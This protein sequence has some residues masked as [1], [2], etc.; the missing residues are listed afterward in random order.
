MADVVLTHSIL[1]FN[2]IVLKHKLSSA[3][4][5]LW[6]PDFSGATD[7]ESREIVGLGD[8]IRENAAAEATEDIH[9]TLSYWYFDENGNDL[10]MVEGCSMG[11]ALAYPTELLFYNVAQC[12]LELQFLMDKF[13]IVY[14][15]SSLDPV[16]MFVANWIN[17]NQNENI[18]VLGINEQGTQ[19]PESIFHPMTQF[20]DLKKSLSGSWLD[21]L[22]GFLTKLLQP[23]QRKNV[24]IL[25]N[26]KFEDY[27]NRRKSDKSKQF[28]IIAPIR[29]NLKIGYGNGVFWQRTNAKRFYPQVEIALRDA[30]ERGWRIKSKVIP[31]DLL[32]SALRQFVFDHWHS[33]FS[34][35]LH[36][37][38]LFRFFK[39]KLAV[40][41]S[42]STEISHLGAFAAKIVGLPVIVMAHGISP[43][44]NYSIMNRSDKLFDKYCSIGG[45]D[46]QKYSDCGLV[47]KDIEEIKFPW[48]SNNKHTSTYARN[49]Q[50]SERR[51]MLLPLDTGFSLLMSASSIMNHIKQ[52]IE[53]CEFCN[54][55][56]FGIKFRTQ[57]EANAFG[58]TVGENYIFGR[59]IVVYAGY[60]SLSNYFGDIDSIIGPF[61]SGTAECG[62]AN[63]DYFCFQDCSIYS[64]NPNVFYDSV[65]T[66]CPIA[67]NTDELRANILNNR[68]F[69]EGHDATSLVSVSDDFKNACKEL[70][71][72]FEKYIV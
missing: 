43:W 71:K 21:N 22:I 46:N 13:E 2:E 47:K 11:T 30:N 39:V 37:I 62:L 28:S 7:C 55:Q 70:D 8:N 26:G 17:K 25:D 58:L 64:N 5:V 38:N 42:E 59:K 12:F 72:T 67:S 16:K 57:I 50:G 6:K 20:R 56:I 33:A 14:I 29:R 10:S 34:Y 44:S 48:F 3:E 69:C 41:C 49:S 32:Q 35:F 9:K 61:T 31:L 51:A 23:I 63:I 19:L 1:R 60:G 54:I 36:Y 68:T 15:D 45:Y 40:F 53:V 52:M 24:L 65:R 18:E 66:I 4:M 27:L